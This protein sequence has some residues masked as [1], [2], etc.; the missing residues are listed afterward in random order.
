MPRCAELLALR[1]LSPRSA[2]QHIAP[3]TSRV[4]WDGCMAMRVVLLSIGAFGSAPPPPPPPP[5]RRPSSRQ[6]MWQ[7]VGRG[8]KALTDDVSSRRLDGI[9]ASEA[10][11][12]LQVSL[13]VKWRGSFGFSRKSLT[14]LRSPAPAPL[15][16]FGSAAKQTPQQLVAAQAR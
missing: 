11:T 14:Q 3:K 6:L 5:S 13:V 15:H 9:L 10:F 12:S 8:R 2:L 16:R 1:N 4:A 7:L